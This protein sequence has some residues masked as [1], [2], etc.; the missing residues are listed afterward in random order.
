[1]ARRASTNQA[2]LRGNARRASRVARR[3]RLWLGERDLGSASVASSTDPAAAF[4]ERRLGSASVGDCEQLRGA[5]K[6]DS[7]AISTGEGSI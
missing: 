2:G 1:M 5:N 3:A 4:G 6:R 7:G